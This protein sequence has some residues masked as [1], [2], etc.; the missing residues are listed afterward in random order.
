GQYTAFLNAVGATD[1]YGL[2]NTN[3]ATDVSIVGIAQNGASGS[4]TY[5]VIGSANHPVTYVSW[6]D[7]ARFANWLQNGQPTG[8]QNGS[9][10]EVGAY[11]LNGAV[12]DAALLAIS[13][14]TGATWFI[15]SDNEWYKAAYHQPA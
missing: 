8:P 2:Y 13:R 11:T 1:T 4:Y 15:P 9:T 7:A 12:S 14:N 3:M 5:S 6:G 10:T